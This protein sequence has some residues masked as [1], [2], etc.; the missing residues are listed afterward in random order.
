MTGNALATWDLTLAARKIEYQ[1]VIAFLTEWAKKWVFQK[2]VAASGYEHFQIR[3]SLLGNKHRLNEM[4][5][6]TKHYWPEGESVHWSPTSKT[7]HEGQNFNYV[8]KADTRAPGESGPWSDKDYEAPPPLTRQLKVFHDLYD[9]ELAYP[10]QIKV[11]Q[12]VTE[13]DDRSIRMIYDVYGNAGKSI[14]AEYL[15]YHGLAFEIPA[16]RCAEDI[17]QC[18]MSIKPKKAYMVDLPRGMKKDKMAEF[19]SG[20]ECV[21]N[22]RAYDKRYK[23]RDVRFDRP[24][25][26]V[27]S[28]ELPDF[29]L[30]IM[31][32]WQIWEMDIAHDITDQ[33]AKFIQQW[34]E[35]QAKWAKRRAKLAQRKREREALTSSEED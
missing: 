31:D 8:M 12:M 1:Q 15:N 24:Q 2:E 28:N 13:V 25:I 11:K 19:Y 6:L 27:F 22:G 30:L 33:T 5:A 26:I 34:R 7:V 29:S 23:F 18:V 35:D 4:V 17:M 10:W 20:L 32:R 3:L 14:M 9:R 16:M 21:K